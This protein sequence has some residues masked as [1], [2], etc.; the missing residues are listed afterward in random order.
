MS[1]HCQT[2][3]LIP[4]A[5]AG[6]AFAGRRQR[7]PGQGGRL[8]SHTAPC[9]TPTPP[10]PS[11]NPINLPIYKSKSTAGSFPALSVFKAFISN[12]VWLVLPFLMPFSFFFFFGPQAAEF[13]E[14][15][16]P[17]LHVQHPKFL[18]WDLWATPDPMLSKELLSSFISF[19][20]PASFYF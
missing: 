8:T 4:A 10:F 2:K 14:A 12:S 17:H 5:G 20:R 7:L 1:L 13:T 15:A 19:S 6:Q 9:H 16:A 18:L 11:G 3:C